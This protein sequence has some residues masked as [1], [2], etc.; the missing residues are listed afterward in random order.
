MSDRPE[1]PE[2]GC[3]C[4]DVH[5]GAREHGECSPCGTP[6]ALHVVALTSD[7]DNAF[8]FCAGC[9]AE[10][11]ASGQWDRCEA[12]ALRCVE[13]G[14]FDIS[15]DASAR[16]DFEAQEFVLSGCQDETYCE[17][18]GGERLCEWVIGE[19]SDVRA[20]IAAQRELDAIKRQEQETEHAARDGAAEGE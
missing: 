19:R 11:I 14:S 20:V 12:E 2:H 17:P 8:H 3:E 13:C 4:R 18:C 16:W 7:P 1:L 5:C 10:A 15:T 9:Y 6:R